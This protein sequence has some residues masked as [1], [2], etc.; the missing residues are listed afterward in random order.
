MK[1]IN[2]NTVIVTGGSGFLGKRLQKKKS[3]W[4]YLSSKECDLTNAKQVAELFGDIKPNAILHL[5]AKVGGIKENIENQ[6][7]FYYLNTIINTNVIHQA[8][9]AG[10][11]RILSSLSTCAFPDVVDTYPF[12]E[13]SLLLGPPAKTNMSYGMTKRMLHIASQSYR[14]QYGRNYSTFCPSNI[15]GPEDHFNK[16]SSH[17]IAALIHKVSQ[18]EDGDTLELWGS[19]KPLRQ[20]L[21]VDDLCDIIPI[22]LEKH[23]TELPL[24]VAPNENLS[25]KNMSKILLERIKKD[26]IISFNG[27]RDG[28]FRKD[29]S[30]KKLLSLIGGYDFTSFSDGV[31]KTYQWY[32][33]N[34]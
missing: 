33:E 22:L 3:D 26:V 19:G 9:L 28:Q 5:A 34:K 1:N 17:F 4:L 18:M 25:I 14:K 32:L 2:Y 23:N 7:E 8:H 24:I 30:N 20:Q 11:E 6:A 29:G 31:Q 15:Y 12:N 27:E 16:E 21:Y 10:I 13:D